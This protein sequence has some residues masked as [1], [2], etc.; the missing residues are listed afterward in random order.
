MIEQH[1]HIFNEHKAIYWIKDETEQPGGIGK[2]RK[3]KAGVKVYNIKIKLKKCPVR[4]KKRH[5][6][7]KKRCKDGEY[8]PEQEMNYS[9]SPDSRLLHG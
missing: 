5:V 3:T 9:P 8:E 4:A 2:K 1:E 7:C 6:K